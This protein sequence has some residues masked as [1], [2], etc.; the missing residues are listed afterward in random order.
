MVKILP[1]GIAN[2]KREPLWSFQEICDE[3]GGCPMV[4][5]Q[6]MRV[7]GKLEP[8]LR[9]SAGMTTSMRTY[10]RLS[11]VKGFLRWVRAN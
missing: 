9:H 4:I 6:K 1:S 8:V 11:E 7:Y 2:S 3:L 10:Y 5:R